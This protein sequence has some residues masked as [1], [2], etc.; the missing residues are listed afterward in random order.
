MKDARQH[1]KATRRASGT[2]T[3]FLQCLCSVGE[4]LGKEA[5]ERLQMNSEGP[6]VAAQE[7]L[8][9]PSVGMKHERHPLL[10]RRLCSLHEQ[11]DRVALAALRQSCKRPQLIMIRS[12]EAT[13]AEKF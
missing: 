8:S 1:T 4:S 9:L 3:T 11:R 2:Q 12:G 5:A 13:E 10:L 7:S 6:Q